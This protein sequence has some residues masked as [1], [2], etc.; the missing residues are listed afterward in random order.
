[1]FGNLAALAR[2][3]TRLSTGG[4]HGVAR[5]DA[6]TTLL[7]IL[8]V[9]GVHNHGGVLLVLVDGPVEDVVILEGLADEQVPEDLPQVRVI[10]LVVKTQRAGVVQVDGEL[11]G[12]SPAQNLGGGG[13]LLLHDT[14]VLLLLG[15]RLQALPG[16][17]T[18]AEVEHNVTQGLH[19]VTTGL[20][21][22]KV[23]VDTGVTGSSGKVLVLTVGDV[24]VSLGV[25]VFLGKTKVNYV[26][27]VSTLANAHQEVVGLDI[28]VDE[29][30]GMDVLDAG[31][32]LVGQ[33]QDGLERELAVAEVEEILQTGPEQVDDH[34]I[35]ITFSTEPTHERDTDTT[36]KG[37]VNTGFILQLGVLC[38]DAFE[39]DGNFL[40]RDD[41]GTYECPSVKSPFLLLSF[42]LPL[43]PTPPL[44]IIE[45]LT[46][47]GRYHRKNHSQSC[48]Q[49]GTC[50][51]HANPKGEK[52]KSVRK[53]S[54]R[55]TPPPATER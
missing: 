22:A 36:S 30:F 54:H 48:G 32:K 40:A 37:L 44:S 49:Y 45:G 9:G 12:K 6:L 27:L 1:M 4:T 55:I 13:H 17:G 43:H 7:L 47:R 2:D 33:Q 46:H 38:L 3:T 50:Y 28:T 23:G 52:R 53:P 26:D 35:V 29:G 19:I 24:E 8:F 11:V 39:L 15:S 42:P 16:Q 14:V 18:T 34:G 51:R 5:T 21:D 10:G 41:V 25:T 31:Y 20:F